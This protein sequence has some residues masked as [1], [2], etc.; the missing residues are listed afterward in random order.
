MGYFFAIYF[1]DSFG[2]ELVFVSAINEDLHNGLLVMGF[3]LAVG[4]WLLA[5]GYGSHVVLCKV[6]DSRG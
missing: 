1:Y 3:D 2:V 4:D 5:V 6:F